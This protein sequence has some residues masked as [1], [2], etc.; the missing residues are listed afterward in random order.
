MPTPAATPTAP[1]PP[2]L[3]E[4]LR[5]RRWAELRVFQADLAAAAGLSAAQLCEIERGTAGTTEA[6]LQR[7]AAA[8][9]MDYADLAAQAA[10]E[11]RLNPHRNRLA[12]GRSPDREEAAPP[13]VEGLPR[14]PRRRRRRVPGPWLTTDEAAQVLGCSRRTVSYLIRHGRLA[15]VRMEPKARGHQRRW[16]VAAEAV[17]AYN[18]PNEGRRWPR[19]KERP[20]AGYVSLD[21]F[22]RRVGVPKATLYRRMADGTLRTVKLGNRRWVPREELEPFRRREVA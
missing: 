5:R 11:G 21:T 10:R 6:T 3:G 13:S 19:R 16:L 15:P 7:L 22:A 12:D 14:V 8:L 18:P 4:R 20:P 2:T 9:G 17:T 1:T